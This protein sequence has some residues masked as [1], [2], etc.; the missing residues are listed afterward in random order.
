MGESPQFLNWPRTDHQTNTQKDFLHMYWRLMDRP[1]GY[2]R[3]DTWLKISAKMR[4]TKIKPG[5]AE[6]LK[7]VFNLS[8][9]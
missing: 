9:N 4:H 5:A 1:E 6:D 8:R 7:E 3:Q 2:C